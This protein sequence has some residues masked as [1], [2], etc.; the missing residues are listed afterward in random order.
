MK[1]I[2]AYKKS[3]LR[4]Y[5]TVCR[6]LGIT[7]QEKEAIKESFGVKSSRNLSEEQLSF[8]IIR[9]VSGQDMTS[10]PRTKGDIWR[11]RAIAAV[12]AW[13]RAINKDESLEIIKAIICRA[14][15]NKDF[16][17]IPVS[18]LR[19]VYYEFVQ[20]TKTIDTTRQVKDGLVE[21]LKFSN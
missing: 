19:A 21:F 8:L 5:H 11:K 13:I 10:A 18:R 12:G 2:T 7:E 1:T 14:T 3:L 6:E 4:K 16:N 15:G 17:R 20:K 9:L